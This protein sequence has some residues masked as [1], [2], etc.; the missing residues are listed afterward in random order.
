MIMCRRIVEMHGGKIMKGTE[1]DPDQWVIQL[2]TGAPT[3]Q[4]TDAQIAIQQA[5]QYARDISLM[6][7]RSRKKQAVKESN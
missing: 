1:D 4:T 6:M 2:P 5:E 3:W 7:T